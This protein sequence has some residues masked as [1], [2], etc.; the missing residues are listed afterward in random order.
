[1]KIYP[2]YE[3]SV[4]DNHIVLVSHLRKK[5]GGQ[6]WLIKMVVKHSLA[7]LRTVDA[8]LAALQELTRQA[9]KILIIYNA[10]GGLEEPLFGEPIEMLDEDQ[11][12]EV[13]RISLSF[14]KNL[15]K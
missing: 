9:Y 3:A 6:W 13:D 2:E 14:G 5:I 7:N 12:D 4:Q 11:R 10:R 1:M 15:I 8:H